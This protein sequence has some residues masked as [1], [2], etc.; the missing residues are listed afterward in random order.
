[1]VTTVANSIKS[2]QKPWFKY[3]GEADKLA[4][5]LMNPLLGKPLSTNEVNLSLLLQGLRTKT[6]EKWDG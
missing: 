3:E 2:D 6:V 5:L 4:P 1:M